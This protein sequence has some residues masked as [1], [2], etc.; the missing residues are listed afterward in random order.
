M[1]P[2][3][4]CIVAA[5]AARAALRD[6]PVVMIVAGGLSLMPGGLFLVSMPGFTRWIAVFDVAIVAL[7]VLLLRSHPG[8]DLEVS[9]SRT[10]E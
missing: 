5:S 8:D 3:F 4:F 6:E 10:P 7:G 9:D 2:I 1:L